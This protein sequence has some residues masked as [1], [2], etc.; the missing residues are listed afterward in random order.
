MKKSFLAFTDL[1]HSNYIIKPW[2]FDKILNMLNFSQLHF[3]VGS[4]EEN[5]LNR[6]NPYIS[7]RLNYIFKYYCACKDWI[8]Y[9]LDKDGNLL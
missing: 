1:I 6:N 7:L 9:G 5:F 3:T 2:T 8:Q 4:L